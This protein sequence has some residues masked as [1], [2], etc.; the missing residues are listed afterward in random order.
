MGINFL[1]IIIK[2]SRFRKPGRF[3]EKKRKSFIMTLFSDKATSG[4]KK[5]L[6][7]NSYLKKGKDFSNN[8]PNDT[9]PRFLP[10]I[11]ALAL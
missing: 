10:L 4:K 11:P 6:K 9:I 8:T 7:G 5:S 3:L 2:P 1:I